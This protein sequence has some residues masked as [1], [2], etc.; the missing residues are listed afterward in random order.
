MGVDTSQTRKQTQPK[1][2]L[3]IKLRTRKVRGI[4]K[5]FLANTCDVTLFMV[6]YIR[7]LN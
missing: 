4:S 7:V 6:L 2:T 3:L 5:I 1:Q